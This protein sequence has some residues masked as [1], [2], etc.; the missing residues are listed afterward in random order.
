MKKTL[1][2]VVYYNWGEA[3]EGWRL[4]DTPGL[5]VIHE[6]MPPGTSEA[7]HYHEKAQQ[8]FYILQGSATFE[9]EGEKTVVFAGEGIH[10]LPTLQH[11]IINHTEEKIF[12]TVT[13]QPNTSGDRVNC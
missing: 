8:F 12:F 1:A 5:S 10:I 7:L 11:R 9:I 2:N 6:A 13:S 3:C 4:V